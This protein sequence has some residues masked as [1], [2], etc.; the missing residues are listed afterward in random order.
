LSE[1]KQTGPAGR[2]DQ[3]T[4]SLIDEAVLAG[5]I[6]DI[7]VEQ[8]PAALELFVAE[9]SRRAADLR[10]ATEGHDTDTEQLRRIAHGAKGSAATFGAPAVA[11]AARRLEEACKSGQPASSLPALIAAL[12]AE[13]AGAS[14]QVRGRIESLQV[15]RNG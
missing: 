8:L 4:V 9:M 2:D 12:L 11:A 1:L 6:E 14:E 5:L 10:R 13:M 15:S 3:G 7:G